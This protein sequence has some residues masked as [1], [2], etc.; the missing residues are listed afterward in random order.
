MRWAASISEQGGSGAPP[1]QATP[2]A[3]PGAGC[4]GPTRGSLLAGE[5]LR[6]DLIRP[7]THLRLASD[8]I[9]YHISGGT[10]LRSMAVLASLTAGSDA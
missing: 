1:A 9:T 3:P 8:F 4:S 6:E 2:G 7:D 10:P 5:A